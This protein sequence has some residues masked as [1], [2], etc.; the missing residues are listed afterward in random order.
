MRDSVSVSE[1][2]SC[3]WQDKESLDDKLWPPKSWLGSFCLF[4][5]LR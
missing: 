4:L 3:F 1:L 5:M 2:R